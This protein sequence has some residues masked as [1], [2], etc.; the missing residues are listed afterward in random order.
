MIWILEAKIVLNRFAFWKILLIVYSVIGIELYLDTRLFK[1]T[2]EID[3]WN[4]CEDSKY[5]SRIEDLEPRS[6]I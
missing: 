6:R 1:K 5:I 3:I 2:Q 4:K